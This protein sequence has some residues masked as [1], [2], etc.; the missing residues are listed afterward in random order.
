MKTDIFTQQILSGTIQLKPLEQNSGIDE[1]ILE[2]LKD[3]IEG[4][5]DSFGY[6]KPDSVRVLKRSIGMCQPGQF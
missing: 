5:C 2:K 3:K 6:I 4:K 1:T